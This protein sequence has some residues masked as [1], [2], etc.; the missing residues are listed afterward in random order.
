[1]TH[2]SN[3]TK[4]LQFHE[5]KLVFTGGKIEALNRGT[6]GRIAFTKACCC[7]VPCNRVVIMLKVGVSGNTAA[8]STVEPP[9]I[10][11]PVENN[12][13]RPGTTLKW[14]YH[15]QDTYPVT[16][17]DGTTEE[18]RNYHQHIWAVEYCY[19]DYDLIAKDMMAP[20]ESYYNELLEWGCELEKEW[21]NV[22][23]T[24]S[25]G[26]PEPE[27]YPD[28]SYLDNPYCQETYF[29][30][31]EQLESGFNSLTDCKWKSANEFG[32]YT[33][34]EC[35]DCTC[36]FS[37]DDPCPEWEPPSVVHGKEYYLIE[38][39]SG[40]NHS[41]AGPT[42]PAI[43]DPSFTED[44][45][46]VTMMWKAHAY[47]QFPSSTIG[48]NYHTHFWALEYCYN[49]ENAY[50]SLEDFENYLILWACDTEKAWNNT[51]FC[52]GYTVTQISEDDNNAAFYAN[53]LE[54]TRSGIDAI[55]GHTA[56]GEDLLSFGDNVSTCGDDDDRQIGG[57][58]AFISGGAIYDEGEI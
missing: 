3:I 29:N 18:G 10:D 6:A 48:N 49:I 24:L 58:G 53:K 19:N 17:P 28:V 1:M 11:I 42:E 12:G 15:I 56:I 46:S 37:C 45:S 30:I 36:D 13:G 5:G 33:T 16:M 27:C 40:G 43:G 21:L 14:H 54:Q 31:Q 9:Y 35:P 8:G 41:T 26:Q 38:I 22:R 7:N 55:T 20:A 50:C 2:N 32:P 51:S 47:D 23:A 44:G 4:K 52:D 57:R 39:G 25:P 34:S